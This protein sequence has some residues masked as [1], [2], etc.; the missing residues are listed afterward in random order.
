[1]HLIKFKYGQFIKRSN[2]GR[3]AT[4]AF[5]LLSAAV[6]LSG[7][8]L[9]HADTHDVPQLA[10]SAELPKYDV[11]DTIVL[12]GKLK[13][14][15]SA[16]DANKAITLLV[17]SPPP[18][19]PGGL[20]T[21]NQITP[22]S[23]GTFKFEIKTGGDRWKVSGTYTFELNFELV[24]GMTTV[25]LEGT[26]APAPPPTVTCAEGSTLV[27]GRCVVDMPTTPP[28]PPAPACDPGSSPVGGECVPDTPTTPP[29]PPPPP[30]PMCDEGERLVDGECVKDQPTCGPGTELVN[31]QCTPIKTEP[32]GGGC[33]I[34]TAAY[35]TELA[36]QVQMLRE[37]RDNT[38]MGTQS[39]SAFMAGFNEVY[40]TFSPTIA[41]WERQSPLFQDAVRAF[42]TPMVSSLSIMGMAEG[43]SDAEVLGL[44]LSVIAL[45][46]GMYVAAPALVAIGIR[47]R[48]QSRL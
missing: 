46:L 10:V 39:G 29:P 20:V 45:N 14:F 36:P 24:K 43:G 35:G 15:D 26:E 30:A 41:D 6:L 47:R 12:T 7:A 25:I 2:M 22:E 17:K 13:D 11:G 44:G 48:I 3:P 4:L 21:I 1:M 23:D 37:I 31:G 34:A 19:A 5:A 28:P 38:V 18:D 32:S 8:S 42:I 9:A 33:L 16:K 40:Y 27:D